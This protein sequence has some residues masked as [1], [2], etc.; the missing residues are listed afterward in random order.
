MESNCNELEG[1]SLVYLHK[2]GYQYG[3]RRMI[4]GKGLEGNK[5][6]VES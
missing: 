5:I 6:R 4:M 2:K 1:T 3:Q